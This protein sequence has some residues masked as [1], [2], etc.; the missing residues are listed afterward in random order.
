MSSLNKV[1]C[2]K[3]QGIV[4]TFDC[5]RDCAVVKVP[6]EENLYVN[7][8][9]VVLNPEYFPTEE[10]KEEINARFYTPTVLGGRI[11]QLKPYEIPT[12]IEFIDELP[13]KEGSEKVDYQALEQDAIKKLPQ[14]KQ[15]KKVDN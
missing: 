7:K 10:T 1:Y 4:S 15:L 14:S 8:A 11:I 13:R 9:Y 12:Y 3:V 6:D 2:D 5:V